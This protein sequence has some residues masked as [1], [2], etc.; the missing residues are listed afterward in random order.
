MPRQ[1]SSC[2]RARCSKSTRVL[3]CRVRNKE[4]INDHSS[5]PSI[6]STALTVFVTSCVSSSLRLRSFRFCVC[7][8]CCCSAEEDLLFEELL[9]LLLILLW[10]LVLLW[11]PLLLLLL[12]LLFD[13]VDLWLLLLLLPVCVA[14]CCLM[15]VM[16]TISIHVSKEA[17]SAVTRFALTAA[18]YKRWNSSRI[19]WCSAFTELE[20]A[21]APAL[22]RA[23]APFAVAAATAAFCCFCCSSNCLCCSC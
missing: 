10:V 17:F 3:L 19:R 7:S 18:G 2:S 22:A 21:A 11:S 12:L 8:S 5:L 20:D 16:S 9:L 14:C 6:P 23:D 13:C 4:L 1:C 15:C